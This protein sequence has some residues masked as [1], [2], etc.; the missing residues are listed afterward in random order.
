MAGQTTVY[1]DYYDA[2]DN[3]LF[4]IK[5]VNF[6]AKLVSEDYIPDPSHKPAD[7]KKYIITS[8]G[9]LKGDVI[10][11]KGMGDIV[12]I[13]KDKT[14]KDMNENKEETLL[15]VDD[16]F[17]DKPEKKEKIK[18]TLRVEEQPND[19]WD[20]LRENGIKYFV[21]ES[22]NLKTLCFCEEL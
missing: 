12:E 9:A 21:V 4:D 14:R 20:S 1:K 13:M 10:F 6:N 11:T 3:K 8:L 7:V 5:N 2:Y 19:F 16:I 17:R 15:K 18:D 22:P